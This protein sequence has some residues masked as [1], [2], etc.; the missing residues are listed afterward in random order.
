M[1][2]SLILSMILV[3]GQITLMFAPLWFLLCPFAFWLDNV[4]RW[5]SQNKWYDDY[6]P[7]APADLIDYYKR[8]FDV[9]GKA[10]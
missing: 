1:K 9:R 3:C 7:F 6:G 2:K 5:Y 8:A 4:I 10:V